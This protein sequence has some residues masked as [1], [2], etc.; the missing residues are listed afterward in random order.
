MA[1][2][3]TFYSF[4]G[5]TGRS[6]GLSNAAYYLASIG[7]NIA[8]I[9]LDVEAAGLIK[10]FDIKEPPIKNVV[11][12]LI[13]PV[14]TKI[15]DTFTLYNLRFMKLKGQLYIIPAIMNED[16]G[17]LANIKWNFTNAREFMDKIKHFE[18]DY[19]IDYFFIDTRSGQSS[20]SFFLNLKADVVVMFSRIDGQGSDGTKLLLSLFRD[21]GFTMPFILVCS[22]IPNH[23]SVADLLLKFRENIEQDIDIQI[24]YNPA[25][26]AKEQIVFES[27]NKSE[28]EMGIIPNYINLAKKIMETVDDHE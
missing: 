11:D 25:L 21:K 12:W 8:C 20:E 7:K 23:R 2:I 4:K 17:R 9:D 1:K 16:P 10:I 18:V 26:A 15:K 19:K 27:P 24:P 5:G 28:F 22:S 6:L 13:N 3:I 14:S